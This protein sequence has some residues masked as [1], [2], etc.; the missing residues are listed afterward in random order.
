[1][2]S[3]SAGM[4]AQ[5]GRRYNHAADAKRMP[6]TG[7]HVQDAAGTSQVRWLPAPANSCT[8]IARGHLRRRSLKASPTGEKLRTMWRLRRTCRGPGVVEGPQA[9]GLSASL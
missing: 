2:G 9:H 4:Q 7:L 3:L 1:V 8:A 6:S 5:I